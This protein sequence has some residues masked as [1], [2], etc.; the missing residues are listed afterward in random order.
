MKDAVLLFEMGLEA[1]KLILEIQEAF[2]GVVLGVGVGLRE[3]QG[4]D[5]YESEEACAGYRELDEKED[6]A[7]IRSEDLNECNSS[8]SFFDA[9]GM[10]FHLPAFM[11]AELRGEYDYGMPY[12]YT[13]LEEDCSERFAI[14]SD[15]QR[16]AVRDFLLILLDDPQYVS[17]RNDIERALKIYWR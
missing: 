6:W 8:L 15:A 10:R 3:A 12:C 14:L 1:D 11:I 16:G 2:A 7:K 4:L 17:K 9:E 5:D 13:Y